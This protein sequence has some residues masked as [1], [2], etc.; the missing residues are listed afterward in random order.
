V[1]VPPSLEQCEHAVQPLAERV[2]Q[3]TTIATAEQKLTAYEQ[4]AASAPGS[5]AGVTKR[6]ARAF[7]RMLK[8]LIHVVLQDATLMI[9]AGRKHVV[10][11]LPIFKTREFLDFQMNLLAAVAAAELNDPRDVAMDTVLPWTLSCL[12]SI[13]V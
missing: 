9:H 6:T 1:N 10:F 7:I 8:S 4:A 3:S 12:A 13:I 5:R 2:S 11:D